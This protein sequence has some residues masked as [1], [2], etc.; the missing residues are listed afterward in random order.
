MTKVM[1]MR[2]FLILWALLLAFEVRGQSIP[3]PNPV[4]FRHHLAD[5]DS[6]LRRPAG[7]VDVDAMVT[8]LSELGV[9]TYYW[10]IWHAATDWDDLKAFLPKAAQTNIEVWVYL[11]PPSES[12]PNEGNLYSEP[13]RLD[14][15]RW[16]DEIGQLSRQHTNLT[17]WVVDDFYAN[18]DLFTPSYLRQ[19]QARAKRANP[20]LAFL[21][22][23]Y[24][25]EISPR[26][27]EDYRP[28]IDGVVVAYLQDR[29]EIE[30]I[31]SLLNDASV[32]PASELAHPWNTPSREYDYVMASQTAKVLPGERYLLRFR[33][34]DSFAGPMAGYHFKQLLVDDAVVWEE[35]VAGGSANWQQVSVDVTRNA[36]GRT[37]LVVA[38][39]LLDKKGVSNFGVRWTVGKLSAENLQL[40]ADL[41]EPQRWTVSQQG[42]FAT[43]FGGVVKH[44]ER[45]FHVPFI[46]MTAGDT[47]EFR[48]RHGEP[49][50]PERIAEQLG[51][52]LQAWRQGKCDG[53]VTYCL[54]K[55]PRSA[56]FALAQKLF[57]QFR[58]SN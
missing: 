53:V 51:A 13:F 48:L 43:G 14:Y 24:F 1:K 45:R 31:W 57:Q 6:E 12:P 52:S 21:P 47:Q 3:S 20:R 56:T 49:A 44:G 8:R 40:A 38:F 26:F 17:A 28:V 42:A 41:A 29:E 18:H 7:R 35:D 27:V 23:M 4:L 5:Y 46:S 33:E 30:R 32:P 39:R 50:T 11:V 2:P 10:L 54:D 25:D 34:R 9:T 58:G 55:Q 37:N 22:L 16:A 15:P 19:L 36:R